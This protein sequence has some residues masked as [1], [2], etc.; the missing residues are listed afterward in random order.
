MDFSAF[1]QRVKSLPVISTSTLGVIT[2]KVETLKVQISHWKKKGWVTSLRKG[3]YLLGPQD[4]TV[5]PPLFYLA[6]QIFIPSYVSLESAL[7]HYRLIPE[8]VSAATSVTVRKT[9]RFENAFGVFTYQHLRPEGF[10]GFEPTRVSEDLT[11]LV[12][13][14][15]KAVVDFLYFNLPRFSVSDPSVFTDSYRFQNISGLGPKRLR[16]Y[17]KR[18]GTKKLLSV[19]ELFIREILT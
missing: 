9:C 18:F 1:K 19:V 5:E 8:F 3:L 2:D 13:T 10:F 12:A 11:A 4:R 15:E 7:A 17:A 14:P 16:A 6:N